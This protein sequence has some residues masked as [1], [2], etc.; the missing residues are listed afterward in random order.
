MVAH[1]SAKAEYRAIAT[2]CCEIV[3]LLTLFKDLGLTDLVPSTLAYDNQAA[4]HITSNPVFHERTKHIEVDCHYVWDQLKLNRVS[5]IHVC[6][7][8]Q[9]A[10]VFTKPLPISQ[11][12][13]LM[14]K[15]GIYNIFQHSTCGG[16][17]NDDKEGHYG[18]GIRVVPRHCFLLEYYAIC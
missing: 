5:P 3:W 11:H 7:K 4:L 1:S 9:L 2:T 17:W 12:N 15:L 6:S 10:D 14:S 8:D 16:V 18:G 13:Y